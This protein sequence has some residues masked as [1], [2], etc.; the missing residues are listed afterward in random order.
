MKFLSNLLA[1]LLGLFIFSFFMFIMLVG[2]ISVSSSEKTVHVE[3]NSVLHIVLSGVLTEQE[4]DDP[5]SEL[6]LPTG[7]PHEV[8]LKELKTAIRKAKDDPKITGIFLE[9]RYFSSGYAALGEL[10]KGLEDF[11]SSGK[12]IL[13][14]SEVYTEKAYYIASA[15]DRIFLTPDYG[16]IEFNGINASMVFLKG[17]LDKLG[18][19]AE[20]F[21]VGDYKS[22]VEPFTREE[23]SKESR[24]QL[25]SF[26]N[27]IYSNVVSDIASSRNMPVDEL[28]NIS[29]SMLVRSAA[30]ALHYGLITDLAYYGQ[31]EDT[32]KA[33]AGIAADKSLPK[34]SY[35]KYNKSASDEEYSSD[36]IA[37]IVASG[38]IVSGKGEE[39]QIGSDKFSAEIRK[40]AKSDRVKAIVLRVNSPG[41][42]ALAS[43]VIWNEIEQAKTKKPVI[44]SMSDLAASGGYYI[45]MACDSIVASPMTITGS[46]GVFSL[47]FNAQDF[48]KDK[49]GITT[50]NV[51]T[52][53]YSDIFTQSR[54][55]TASEK[56][57]FQKQTES[58]YSTFTSKAARNR[59]MKIEDLLK[60]ASG[61]VWSG[62]EAKEIGL[63]DEFGTLED[64]ID[65]AADKAN[66]EKYRVVYYP[67]KKSFIE[68]IISEL[69][70]D[71]E[72][73]IMKIR[74][75]VLYP[76]F[77]K[78][79]NISNWNG[80]QTRLPFDIVL[81]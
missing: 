8:G 40:A 4:A 15:A 59:N 44:A 30:D 28:M 1:V 19:E 41:G 56:M 29:D 37:V 16:L 20:V 68:E 26:I 73:R 81:E 66:L 51:N 45:S 38:D 57:I 25:E 70:G 47:L 64:A 21:K 32:L 9:P 42:S 17:T 43:D 61:R 36:R 35:R 77:E 54:P 75:G 13:A 18:I 67:E 49:L 76:Y 60:V 6:N 5:F 69:S 46:I 39:Q 74:L 50:D 65:M 11:K 27:S 3:D 78:V 12:F 71:M 31:M 52:G 63:I 10:K 34:I 33:L 53:I 48:L 62:D 55:L 22:A 2:I 79:K 14:Y 23:M 24:E 58:V 72:S 7:G 80:S